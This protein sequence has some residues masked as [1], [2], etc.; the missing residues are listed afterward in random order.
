MFGDTLDVII[1]TRRLRRLP[2]ASFR[3]LSASESVTLC[4]RPSTADLV[5]TCEWQVRDF[6]LANGRSR[7]STKDSDLDFPAFVKAYAWIFY[8]T[9]E[10][11]GP[12]SSAGDDD[13]RSSDGVGGARGRQ[14][15]RS[16]AIGYGS[17]RGRRGRKHGRGVTTGLG[18]DAEVRRWRQRLGDKRM[19]RLQ[20]VFEA[21]A[22]DDGDSGAE[23][24]GLLQARDLKA[25][26]KE[27]GREVN[28]R[29][30][31]AWCEEADL[32]PGDS[33][34]L[35]DFAYAFHAMF[36]GEEEGMLAP[37]FICTTPRSV[38]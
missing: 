15:S 13:S 9:E 20:S 37:Y 25:C 18:E 14:A 3:I 36:I 30:L 19:H 34:S 23:R 28:Q 11:N 21:W 6:L 7:D 17:K 27:L 8:R 5:G 22:D 4:P 2:C 35:A 10:E 24:M 12:N 33:M 29:K 16:R 38:V 32:A 31:Q 26:F 1:I